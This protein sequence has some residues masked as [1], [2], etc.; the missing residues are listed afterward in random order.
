[1]TIFIPISP[2]KRRYSTNLTEYMHVVIIG[3]GISGVS[4]ARHIRKL[5][6]HKITIISAE[7]KHFF[8]RT[9]LMYIYMGHMRYQDTKPYEDW[10]WEKNRI[11]LVQDYVEHVDVENQLLQLENGG[12]L[13]YDKLV[14]A[15]G[16]KPNKFNWPG[17]DLPGVQGLYSLQDLELLERNTKDIQRAVI[18]GGGLIGIELAEMLLSRNIAVTMLVRESSFWNNVLPAGESEIINKHIREHHIDLQLATEL[19]SIEAGAD[20]SVASVRTKS[21]KQIDCQFVGLTVGVHPNIGFIKNSSIAT[22]RGVVVNRNLETNVAN[23]YAIGDCAEF[24]NPLQGRRPIEQVWYTGKMQGI[25]AA[26]NI[27]GQPIEYQP[28]I[29]FNSAKFLDIEYQTYGTVPNQLAE[30]Q[31]SFYLEHSDHKKCIHLVYDKNT[32]EFLGVNTLGI[33]YRHQLMQEFL[34]ARRSIKYVIEH[35][36]A[37]NFDPEFYAQFEYYLLQ[38][39]N[40]CFPNDKIKKQTKST[41]KAFAQLLKQTK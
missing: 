35:L 25:T 22:N 27:C 8:S 20:G 26:Y 13:A 1:M 6:D 14:I 39:Y 19:D 34:E 16:S 18:V 12:Q 24:Q 32:L 7:S 38:Q 9:A 41:W 10:F 3:N 30:H 21:G 17:Q 2:R 29:W 40:Q 31:A 23:V 11:D 37:A 36:P 33:R 15:A 5:S 28:G 4:C